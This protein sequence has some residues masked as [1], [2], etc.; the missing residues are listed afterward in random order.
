[1]NFY[2]NGHLGDCLWDSILLNKL[3]KTTNYFYKHNK[4]INKWFNNT[5]IIYTT[6]EAFDLWIGNANFTGYDK[7]RIRPKTL[8]YNE[9]YFNWWKQVC[10]KLGLE[11]PFDTKNDILH[12]LIKT[13][14]YPKYNWLIINSE[15]HSGQVEVY[16]KN[17][18]NYLRKLSGR[19]ITTERVEG[20]ECTRDIAPTLWDIGQLAMG[21]KH[22]AGIHTAPFVACISKQTLRQVEYIVGIDRTHRLEYT[23]VDIRWVDTIEGMENEI[24]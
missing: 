13:T 11:F 10:E 18:F 4:Y 12:N 6:E 9:L 23:G 7:R 22:I 3:K 2:N 24:K 15:P 21:C 20:Y 8:Q 1:M 14:N 5:N 19:I 17:K 16:N